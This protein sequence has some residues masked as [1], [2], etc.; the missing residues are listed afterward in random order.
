L[1]FNQ[2]EDLIRKLIKHELSFHLDLIKNCNVK[3]T[4]K[5]S[6]VINSIYSGPHHFLIE[7]LFVKLGLNEADTFKSSSTLIYLHRAQSIYTQNTWRDAMTI[8]R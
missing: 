5:I 4:T 6:S 7:Y 8:K 2:T 3:R 1:Q